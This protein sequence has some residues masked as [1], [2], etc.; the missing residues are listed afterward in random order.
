MSNNHYQNQFPI[1]KVLKGGIEEPLSLEEYE[2]GLATQI[3]LWRETNDPTYGIE[4]LTDCLLVHRPI[5]GDLQDWLFHALEKSIATRGRVTIDE[6]LGLRKKERDTFNAYGAREKSAQ[7]GN[8]TRLMA[9]LEYVTGNTNQRLRAGLVV[10]REQP[11]FDV[12]A[13][14]RYYRDDRHNI[15]IDIEFIQ[16]SQRKIDFLSSFLHDGLSA[17]EKDFLTQS[18]E[19]IAQT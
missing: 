10:H 18:I 11:S 16:D 12:S 14:E 19:T 9:L 17:K 13:L 8:C 15:E 6:A 4:A 7:R 5:P 1:T 3:L 2:T